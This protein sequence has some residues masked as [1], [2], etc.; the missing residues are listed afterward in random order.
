MGHCV[1]DEKQCHVDGV[2]SGEVKVYS[3]RDPGNKPHATIELT[4]DGSEIL[5]IKGKQN[6]VPVDKYKPYI[7]EWIESIGLQDSVE[8]DYLN[9][10]KNSELIARLKDKSI[11]TE[12]KAELF[13]H[14]I[15]SFSINDIKPLIIEHGEEL[16]R[17]DKHFLSELLLKYGPFEE[18]QILCEKLE[19]HDFVYINPNSVYRLKPGMPLRP[20]FVGIVLN[21]IEKSAGDGVLYEVPLYSLWVSEGLSLHHQ[22]RIIQIITGSQLTAGAQNTLLKRLF[23]DR[24]PDPELK[25]DIEEIFKSRKL[26]S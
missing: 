21:S 12:T 15:Y 24:D 7:R 20:G 3:L 17:L 13:S 4:G 18:L 16:Y 6:A 1:G 22:K 2:R 5:E 14:I 26:A 25:A 23:A 9:I 19:E 10:L 8:S 11:N